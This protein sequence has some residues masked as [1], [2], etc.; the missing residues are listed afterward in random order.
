MDLTLAKALKY[1]NR[2]VTAISSRT[3]DIQRYNSVVEGGD[4]EV[5]VLKL[6]EEHQLLVKHLIDLKLAINKAN[7]PIQ[8]FIF[9]I[10]EVK[11]EIKLYEGMSTT[12]GSSRDLYGEAVI[13]Y[14]ALLR[15]KDVDQKVVEL[16]RRLDAVQEKIDVH[17][18]VAKITIE[19]TGLI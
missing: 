10:A 18:H 6:L 1:K 16:N 19:D 11:S 13:K 14:D 4:R 5:D 15:K 8:Q 12:H 3:N 7:Q 17:N 9:E 2:L